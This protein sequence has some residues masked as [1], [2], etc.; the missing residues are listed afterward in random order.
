MNDH[1]TLTTAEEKLADIIWS[2]API[3]SPD[4]VD[5][6]N[7]QLDWKKS[8]TYTVLRRLCEKGIFKN[9]N[10]LVTTQLTRKELLALQSRRFVDQAFSGSLPGFI[11]AFVGGGKL[12]P[13]V[14]DE[15]V[16]LIEAHQE[17]N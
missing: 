13:K 9:T 3:P 7:K 14:A 11:A 2:S 12:P 16:Q 15:L 8:T 1:Y 6:A 5:I 17:E 10:A 4:L